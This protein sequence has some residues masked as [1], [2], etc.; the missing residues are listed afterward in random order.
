MRCKLWAKMSS[1]YWGGGM[2][3]DGYDGTVGGC[4]CWSGSGCVLLRKEEMCL[5]NST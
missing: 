2:A 5:C 3:I 1:A 4:F